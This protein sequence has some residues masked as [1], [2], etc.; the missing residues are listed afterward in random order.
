VGA[1]LHDVFHV[2]LLKK[3]HGEA[4]I[5][6]G[7][8]PLIR[9]D[10]ACPTP[11]TVLHRRLARDQQELLVQWV[12]LT[13]VDASWVPVDEFQKLYPDF[14]LENKLVQQPGRDVMV[15]LQYHWRR[16]QGNNDH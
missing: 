13:V 2:D 6:L 16:K 11:A 8:L 14:K 9:H 7:A 12:G 1:R 4:P 3:F 15:G 10:W 5:A